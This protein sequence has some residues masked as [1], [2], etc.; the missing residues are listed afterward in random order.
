L[1][2]SETA[3]A[4]R[5]EERRT[6]EIKSVSSSPESPGDT[7]AMQKS[8]GQDGGFGGPLVTFV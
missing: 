8:C 3:S 7:A 5:L 6:G 1:S 2:K 4:S